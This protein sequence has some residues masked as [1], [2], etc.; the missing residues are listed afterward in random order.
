MERGLAGSRD[1]DGDR[2]KLSIVSAV[3]VASRC[4]CGEDRGSYEGGACDSFAGR[5]VCCVALSRV[6]RLSAF[7]C[8]VVSRFA[9][10]HL[11]S[12]SGRRRRCRSLVSHGC[13]DE[14]EDLGD[15]L[16]RIEQ[17]QLTHLE[18]RRHVV[19]LTDPHTGRSN[20]NE[21]SEQ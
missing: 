17:T 20:K 1:G 15:V 2:S 19:L 11:L 12:S 3:H 5:F 8:R 16:D 18:A 21:R 4:G 7:R 9:L 13:I 14:C 10:L 6:V